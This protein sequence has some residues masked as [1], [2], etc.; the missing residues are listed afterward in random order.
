MYSNA[1]NA[2]VVDKTKPL[3]F[4]QSYV[5]EIYIYHLHS[6]HKAI[7]PRM[8]LSKIQIVSHVRWIEA[9]N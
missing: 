1:N 2:T 8:L 3:L 7:F 9:N 4:N 5:H 6:M